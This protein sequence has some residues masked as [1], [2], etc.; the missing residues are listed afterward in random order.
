RVAIARAVLKNPPILI[1]DE[2]TS[3]LDAESERLVS[4]A[5][6]RVVA[7]RTV[8]VIAHRQSTVSKADS[9]AVLQGG[10]IAEQGVFSDLM[11]KPD[12]LLA[13]LMEGGSAI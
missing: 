4:E 9:V 12:G 6:D 7:S 11:A 5:V 1:L 10:V 13:N 3:A 2:A 8:L